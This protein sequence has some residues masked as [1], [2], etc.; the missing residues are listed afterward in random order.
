MSQPNED[1]VRLLVEMRNGSID[2]FRC[3]YEQYAP[4][5]YHIA[6]QI[7]KDRMEA[8]DACH[9]VF[10][11]ILKK[12]H[13]YDPSRGSIESWLAVKTRSRCLD[14]LKRKKPLLLERVEPI[15]AAGSSAEE[16]AISKLERETLH[17]AMER[18]PDAQREAL[19]GI[20]FQ[21]QTQRELSERMNRPLGTIKSFVRYGLQNMKKQLGLLGWME[22]S[23]GGKKHGSS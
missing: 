5:V 20:Y 16:R 12:A 23:G 22:P 14:R 1:I 10:V 4:L 15:M 18:I 6:L 11:E 3:F 13:Q 2:A 19:Y 17:I 8:E 7:T 9:D 21:S